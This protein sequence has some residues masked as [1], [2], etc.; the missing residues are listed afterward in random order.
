MQPTEALQDIAVPRDARR[1]SSRRTSACPCAAA[2]TS[3]TRAPKKAG[4]I[5]GCAVARAAWTRRRTSCSIS[6][7]SPTGHEFLGLGAYEVSDD[8]R[9]LAFSLDTTGYRD[10]TLHVKELATGRT[11]DETI[12]RTGSVVWAADNRTHLLHDRGAGL[13]ARPIGSGA[14]SWAAERA[15]CSTRRRTIDSI[16]PP[17][18]PTTSR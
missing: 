6:T 13:E 5:P 17:A 1:G 9:W 8:G 10:Y 15:N 11:L 4:S 14:A 2:G 7:R 16:C 18:G 3:T 12:E